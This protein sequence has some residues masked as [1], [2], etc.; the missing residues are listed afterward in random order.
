MADMGQVRVESCAKRVRAA[1]GEEVV[2]DSTSALLVWEVPYYPTYY[3]PAPDVRTELLTP[4]GET[5]RSPSRGEATQYTVK[6]GDAVG[7]AYSF[8]DPNMP[9]LRDHYVL[10]WDTMDHWYEEDEEVFV[11]A[12]DP[13]TRIDILPSS[14]RVR[15]EVDGVTIADSSKG[16]FLFE[17]GLPPRYYLPKEDVRMDLLTP[18]DK[19]T[20]CPYKGRASYWSV[21]TGEATHRDLVWGY[22]DPLPESDRIAGMACFYN[23]KAD[24]YLDEV[25]QGRPKTKFS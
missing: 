5:R 4:T 1:L 7:A 9:E 3:F 12:R 16:R 6:A 23:E 15:V 8:H 19:V 2:A 24:I 11:H 13:H 17:T 18:T 14:R 21:D 20:A 10:V 22:E 25:L